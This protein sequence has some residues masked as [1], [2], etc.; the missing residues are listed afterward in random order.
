MNCDVD[1]C[2]YPEDL[3]RWI[4]TE[5]MGE[6]EPPIPD[7]SKGE[8]AGLENYVFDNNKIIAGDDFGFPDLWVSAR[9]NWTT[10][11]NF[12]HEWSPLSFCSDQNFALRAWD[13][14]AKNYPVEHPVE[15]H[16]IYCRQWEKPFCAK[17]GFFNPIE[18]LGTRYAQVVCRLI[19]QLYQRYEDH[20]SW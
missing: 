16:V 1:L 4:A 8:I 19:Y 3:D 9:G 13:Y 17:I 7:I 18:A 10:P 20:S 11:S 12:E 6:P 5:I 15:L 2:E 14:Y